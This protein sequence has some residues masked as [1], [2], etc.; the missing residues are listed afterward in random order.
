MSSKQQR[1]GYSTV[2][3]MECCHVLPVARKSVLRFFSCSL[4]FELHVFFFF[5]VPNFF[6]LNTPRK[7]VNMH[8]II[9]KAAI[10]SFWWE[11]MCYV[12]TVSKTAFWG[13]IIL[14]RCGYR[15]V[16]QSGYKNSFGFSSCCQACVFGNEQVEKVFN[17]ENCL[18]FYIDGDKN[19]PSFLP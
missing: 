17:D 12:K 1:G 5:Y 7:H 14:I 8:T 15:E 11:F 16:C 10:H 6:S 3:Q 19:V 4:V 2:R 9:L 13:G 18:S